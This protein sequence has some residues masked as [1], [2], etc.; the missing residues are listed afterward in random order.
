M[1]RLF[2]TTETEKNATQTKHIK[3]IP[4]F[5]PGTPCIPVTLVRLSP[6]NAYLNKQ[7]LA[8]RCYQYNTDTT[9]V[10]IN[11]LDEESIDLDKILTQI[12]ASTR[13][14]EG[15][16]AF[17]RELLKQ[18]DGLRKD[19]HRLYHLLF[20]IVESG[21]IIQLELLV[22]F[23]A[24]PVNLYDTSSEHELQCVFPNTIMHA[25]IREI[26]NQ[27][28]TETQEIQTKHQITMGSQR[29]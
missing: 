21:D 3:E 4:E 2:T 25:K 14:D 26:F 17:H 6:K 7:L 13:N 16:R 22:R 11:R 19:L 8:H 1:F 29:A 12:R 24:L 10:L 9:D 23:F 15:V 27:Q 28:Q 5:V 18:E 20:D